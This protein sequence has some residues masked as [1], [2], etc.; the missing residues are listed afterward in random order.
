MTFTPPPPLPT[1]LTRCWQYLSCYWP[2]FD[3]TL[4]IGSWDH[5]K[6]IPIVM[7]TFAQATFVLATSVHMRNNTAVNDRILTK[8]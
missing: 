3:Q 5:L 8:F 7:M 1:T 2:D 6:Q 4:K